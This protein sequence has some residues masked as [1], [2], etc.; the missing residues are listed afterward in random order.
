MTKRT[1]L[2]LLLLVT[3][4]SMLVLAPTLQRR[5]SVHATSYSGMS[6]DKTLGEK[7]IGHRSDCPPGTRAC[8]G[9]DCVPVI[10]GCS[11][12]PQE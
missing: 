11:G 8:P 12:L 10:I 2:R 1:Y 7:R 9:G 4:L 5:S 3:M 6:N